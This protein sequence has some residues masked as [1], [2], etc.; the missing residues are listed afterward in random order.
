[1]NGFGPGGGGGEGKGVQGGGYWGLCVGIKYL[2][3]V[4]KLR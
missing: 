1:M 3:G 2:I 4:G